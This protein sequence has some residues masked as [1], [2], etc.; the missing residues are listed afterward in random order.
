MSQIKTNRALTFIFITVLLDIIGLGIIIP[1]LPTL[2]SE[3]INGSVS[4]AARYGG[5][6][7]FSYAIMQFLFAPIL[8]GLSDKYGRRPVLLISL[9]GFGLDYILMALSPTIF[10]LFIGR[11]ISGITGASM[12]T[13]SAY[14]ADV[15]TPE[16]RSQNFGL[17]GAAFGLGFFIGPV[18]GGLLGQYGSR[19]PFFAAAVLV[20][21]NWLYGYFVLPESLSLE[22][23][24]PFDWKRANPA[25]SLLRLRNYP[26][27]S[28]LIGAMVLLYLAGFATQSTWS[29]YTLEKFQWSEA[30]VGFSLG[31]VG[32]LV[33]IVQGGLIRVVVP[34]VGQKKAVFMGLILYAFGFFLFAF[35]PSGW[36]MLVFIIPFAL[37]G[38]AGPT[39]QGIMSSQVPAD[40]QGELQGGLTSLTSLTTIVGPVLMTSLFYWF[41]N[42]GAPI[43]FPGAPFLLASVLT[44]VCLALAMRT[45]KSNNI[46]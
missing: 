31:V 43:Y 12:T 9:F 2:I 35:A 20:L 33:A 3:L 27:I 4:E 26:V 36:L 5:W 38:L 7:M 34:R 28:G 21:L 37:G 44:L 10:W 46:M 15:S 14:I 40:E 22:R 29:Y 1:V 19:I 39:I 23:R 24:R 42:H 25:G 45:F 30:Q 13:A 16:K 11:L 18:I 17:I 6:L 32:L 41:T 8:G